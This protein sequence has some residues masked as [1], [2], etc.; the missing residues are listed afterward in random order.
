MTSKKERTVLKLTLDKKPIVVEAYLEWIENNQL[1]LVKGHLHTT[2]ELTIRKAILDLMCTFNCKLDFL[3]SSERQLVVNRLTE[4]LADNLLTVDENGINVKP[5]GQPFIRTIC[6]ALDD[7]V[8]NN[9]SKT[10]MFS[11]SV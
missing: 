5:D 6:M 11:Q 2:R 4:H 1:P 3:K 7:F 9:G 10:K 8:W